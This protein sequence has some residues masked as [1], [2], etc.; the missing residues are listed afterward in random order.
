MNITLSIDDRVVEQARK[1]AQAMGK[2]LNQA[3]RDHLEQLAGQ[4][5]RQALAEELATLSLRGRAPARGWR[6]AREDAYDD[7]VG[8][9]RAA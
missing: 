1:A 9:R 7:R 8:R 4:A 3:V 2:S 5:Q 6:F